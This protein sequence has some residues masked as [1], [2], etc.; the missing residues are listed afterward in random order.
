MTSP[1]NWD[2]LRLKGM[3][4]LARHGALP[5]ERE[6]DQR[7]EVDL[8]IFGN[9]QTAADSDDLQDAIDYRNLHQTVKQVMEG[10]SKNLLETLAE[11]IA[12]ELLALNQFDGVTVC[13]R[14]PNIPY[15]AIID[16]AEIEITRWR[17]ES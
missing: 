4:F 7:F 6:L 5:P 9:F 17:N 8:T 2:I 12:Q 3:V 1:D 14:K 16:S 13:V 10:P 15:N 11:V